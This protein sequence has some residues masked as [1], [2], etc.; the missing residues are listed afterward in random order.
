MSVQRRGKTN[1]KIISNIVNTE[2]LVEKNETEVIWDINGKQP[3]QYDQEVA[4]Y[5]RQAIVTHCS[6]DTPPP[7]PMKWFGLEMQMRR[8]ATRGVLSLSKCLQLAQRLGMDEQGLEAALLHM[9][10]LF[11][12]YHKV[13]ALRDVVFTDPQVILKVI[14]DLV[15]CKR[16]LAALGSVGVKGSWHSKFKNHAIVSHE[17]L[18]H[19]HFKSHFV[20]GVF[21][22]NH[23]TALMS[24]L[25]IMVPLE[26]GEYLMPA[27]LD[28]LSSVKICRESKLVDPLLVSFPDGCA[29]YGIFSCLVAFFTEK[30]FFGGER[31]SSSLSL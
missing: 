3:K 29:P 6:K 11:L 30:M 25:F 20:D 18:S 16:E 27:L 1:D 24:H 5:F 12:W 23:F 13:P 17:F 21:T 8:S 15:Q 31:Q 7:L 19:Q 26:D 2:C 4:N 9:V 10:N 14:T 22:I 28:P